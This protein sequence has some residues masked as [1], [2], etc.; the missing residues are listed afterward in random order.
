M[1]ALPGKS[2]PAGGSGVGL[3]LGVWEASRRPQGV[4]WT[5]TCVYTEE[6]TAHGGVPCGQRG[7]TSPGGGVPSMAEGGHLLHLLINKAKKIL[8]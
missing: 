6:V 7:G 8:H 3:R 1:R 5:V 4:S 2:R